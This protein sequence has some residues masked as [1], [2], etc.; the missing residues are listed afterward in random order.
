MGVAGSGGGASGTPWLAWNGFYSRLDDGKRFSDCSTEAP[1]LR[2]SILFSTRK[3]ESGMSSFQAG[4]L[5]RC[6]GL[7][8][9][10]CRNHNPPE[11]VYN[12]HISP[13]STKVL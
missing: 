13:E 8:H 9:A 7:M 6:L 3:K 12:P 11:G 10:F 4:S 2:E 1:K 5:D